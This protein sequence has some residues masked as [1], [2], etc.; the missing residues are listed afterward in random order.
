MKPLSREGKSVKIEVKMSPV[1]K[2]QVAEMAL[3]ESSDGDVSRWL[4]GVVEREWKRH[5]KRRVRP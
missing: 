4:R 3:A 1:M 5:L 2:A